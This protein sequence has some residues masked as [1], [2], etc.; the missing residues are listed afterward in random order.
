MALNPA[1]IYDPRYH[2]FES[3]ASLMCEQYGTQNLEIPNK[4][5][6]WRE[7]GD[8]LSAI[9]VFSNEAIPRT[10]QYEDWQDWAEAMVNA[11]NPYTA[12]T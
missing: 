6:D 1:F 12:S 3:W 7:W 9:D 11:V 10:D 2:T 4:N 5:T 8:G